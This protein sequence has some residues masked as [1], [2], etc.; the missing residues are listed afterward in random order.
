[1]SDIS[2]KGLP[3]Q[4]QVI[5]GRPLP[6][7]LPTV[8]DA[9]TGG[10]ELSRVV[11]T[12]ASDQTAFSQVV[13]PRLPGASAFRPGTLPSGDTTQAPLTPRRIGLQRDPSLRSADT[14]SANTT[15]GTTT[16]KPVQTPLD[17]TAQLKLEMGMKEPGELR[18]RAALR[19]DLLEA[20]EKDDTPKITKLLADIPPGMPL[21]RYLPVS[22]TRPF[23][24]SLKLS[25]QK[26]TN[27]PQADK[28][29]VSYLQWSRDRQ[30]VSQALNK[31]D[32][33]RVIGGDLI[34]LCGAL[35]GIDESSDDRSLGRE[36]K[37][38]KAMMADIRHRSAEDLATQPFA[39]TR[40]ML[41]KCVLLKKH[42]D[43]A[44]FQQFELKLEKA[45]QMRLASQ[46]NLNRGLSGSPE[47]MPYGPQG[48][49][50]TDAAAYFAGTVAG[51]LDDE[52]GVGKSKA[53]HVHMFNNAQALLS[54][55]GAPSRINAMALDNLL[56]KMATLVDPAVVRK[57]GT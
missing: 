3:P 18:R 23:H 13:K 6:K 19:D 37:S 32:L 47:D 36:A 30:E 20:L 12:T 40:S 14:A 57:P 24:L 8:Q 7:T 11:S 44:T 56:G 5:S 4:P 1:M 38:I 50:V 41:Q 51:D 55:T 26:Y 10:K 46:V 2:A 39:S 15:P 43:G 27:D 54:A 28:A 35:D 25:A 45:H 33:K 21:S 42:I 9:G 16:A 48:K 31:A 53:E 52:V 29:L 34:K 17:S 22:T 49:L